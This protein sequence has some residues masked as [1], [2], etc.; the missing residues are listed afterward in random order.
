LDVVA[1][2]GVAAAAEDGVFA[3]RSSAGNLHLPA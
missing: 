2:L 1:D 3:L